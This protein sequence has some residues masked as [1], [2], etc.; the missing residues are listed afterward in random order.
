MKS[1]KCGLQNLRREILI[2]NVPQISHTS[3]TL[4]NIWHKRC[5]TDT[6]LLTILFQHFPVDDES[7]PTGPFQCQGLMP[8]MSSFCESSS[9]LWFSL[10]IHA[11]G[12]LYLLLVPNNFHIHT[13]TL[14]VQLFHV[15]VFWSGLLHSLLSLQMFTDATFGKSY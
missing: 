1:W 8:L 9:L 3:I 12:F 13:V 5:S 11:F 14:Q 2:H 6:M 4:T 10:T 7:P 15:T